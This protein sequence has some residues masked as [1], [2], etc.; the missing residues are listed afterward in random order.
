MNDDK[1]EFPAAI[2]PVFLMLKTVILLNIF[3]ETII[4]GLGFY[5]DYKDKKNSIYLK[6][7]LFVTLYIYCHLRA[8]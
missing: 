5:D 1:A 7:N 3:V 8:I 4:N 6:Y 2:T